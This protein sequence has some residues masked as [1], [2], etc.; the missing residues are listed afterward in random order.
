MSREEGLALLEEPFHLE[1]DIVALVKKRL[2][3]S[4]DEFEQLMEAP[5]RTYRDYTT[6]KRTF[7]RMRPF[8]WLMYKLDRV[9]QSFY[10]KFTVPDRLASRTVEAEIPKTIH[11]ELEPAPG[12]PAPTG[13]TVHGE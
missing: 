7:E 9:P 8:F 11:V 12:E 2:G 10:M 6:Y 3:F 4:D 1:S 13:G 5:R